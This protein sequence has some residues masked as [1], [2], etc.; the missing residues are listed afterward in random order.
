MARDRIGLIK[1]ISEVLV[2]ENLRVTGMNSM[3]SKGDVHMRFSVEIRS[4]E[5]LKN[6]LKAVRD[7]KGILSAR[8]A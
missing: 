1:D 5:H 8:R 7:L 2:K 3:M 4:A 6:A